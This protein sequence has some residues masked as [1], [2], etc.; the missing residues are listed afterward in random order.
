MYIAFL[1]LRAGTKACRISYK[2]YCILEL[3]AGAMMM[4]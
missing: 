4:G 3:D 2:A 1:S